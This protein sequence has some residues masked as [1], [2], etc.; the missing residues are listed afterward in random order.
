MHYLSHLGITPKEAKKIGWQKIYREHTYEIREY[1]TR[2]FEQL[3]K[4][5]THNPQPK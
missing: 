4:Q 2:Y 5:L 1:T 3:N